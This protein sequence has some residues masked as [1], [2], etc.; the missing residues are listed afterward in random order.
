MG[1][2]VLPQPQEQTRYAMHLKANPA[3]YKP[4]WRRFEADNGA[5]FALDMKSVSHL[6]YCGGMR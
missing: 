4:E 3:E 5:V 2:A 1:W 6:H